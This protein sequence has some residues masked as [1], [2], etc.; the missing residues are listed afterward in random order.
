MNQIEFF[1][2]GDLSFDM[3]MRPVSLRWMIWTIFLFKA[4]LFV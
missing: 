4:L 3:A 2:C 1:L